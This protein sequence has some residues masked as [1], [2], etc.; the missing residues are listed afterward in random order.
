[1][2]QGEKPGEK[3]GKEGDQP[4]QGGQKGGGDSANTASN[5]AAKGKTGERRVPK[6]AGQSGTALPS[7]FQKTLDA[8]NKREKVKK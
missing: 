5:G 1:M 2:G 6:A 7:E 3:P 8:Y 4:G